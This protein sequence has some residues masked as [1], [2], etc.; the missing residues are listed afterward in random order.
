[1][2]LRWHTQTADYQLPA[3]CNRLTNTQQFV[4]VHLDTKTLLYHMRFPIIS[5][6][7]TFTLVFSL[8]LLYECL[9]IQPLGCHNPIN[10]VV[11]TNLKP[12][13][14]RT[15]AMTL[16][17]RARVTVTVKVIYYL[18][19]QLCNRCGVGGRPLL[20]HIHT[21]AAQRTVNP[22]CRWCRTGT[23]GCLIN[24]H[25]MLQFVSQSYDCFCKTCHVAAVC[26]RTLK[27]VEAGACYII[28]MHSLDSLRYS[29]SMNWTLLNYS[30]LMNGACRAHSFYQ[31]LRQSSEKNLKNTYWKNCDCHAKGQL[32][33]FFQYK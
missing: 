11:V 9:L 21:Q 15:W 28:N 5:N 19:R 31:S 24:V 2:S 1:M 33:F 26:D 10:A 20:S 8:F 27:V 6:S 16:L 3:V 17:S 29:P 23:V 13:N 30:R 32:M 14:Q 12:L 4:C 7:D 22:A 25:T 18:R